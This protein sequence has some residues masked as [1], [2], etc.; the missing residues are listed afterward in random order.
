MKVELKPLDQQVIVITG[1]DSGI[2]LATAREAARRGAAVVLNSRNAQALAQI[3]EELGTAGARVAWHAGDVADPMAMQG[4][5]QVAMDAFGRIDTWVNNAGVTIYGEIEHTPLEDVRR[6]FDTNYFGVV[7]GSLAALPHLR[8]RGGA[9]IN[10]GSVLSGVAIPLQGHYAASKHAVKGFT[11]SLRLELEHRLVPIAVTLIRPAA[12]DTPYT[13]HAHSHMADAD[14]NVPPPVYAPGVVARA[15]LDCAVRPQREVLVGGAAKQMQMLRN[16]PGTL[17]DRY[18][19]TAVWDQQR[20]PL[21]T[22]RRNDALYTPSVSGR[23]RGD[24]DG[25]VMRT[26]AYTHTA[27]HPLQSLLTVGLIGA[28]AYLLSRSGLVGRMDQEVRARFMGGDADGEADSTMARADRDMRHVLRHLEELGPRPIETLTPA[29]ARMQPTPAD[30]VKAML[31]KHGKTPA[32]LPVAAVVDRTIPGP[33]GEIPIRVY[34]PH[35]TGPFPVIVYTHGGGWVIATNDTYDSSAR[36]LCDAVNAVVVSVEYRK[37]PEHRFP[38]AH[39]DALAAYHWVLQNAAELGGD[40]DR[41]AVAGESAGGNLAVSIALLARDNGLP[42]PAHVLAVYP[43]ADGH[44]DSPSYVENADTRPLNRPMMQWFFSHYLRT[45]ADA[46]NPLISLVRA[47]L[48]GLPPTTIITAEI[49][50]LR[51][52][53]ERLAAALRA[54]GVEVDYHTHDGVTHEFFGMAMVVSDAA[55]ALKQAAAGLKRGL[56]ERS[57]AG[58]R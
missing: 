29:E 46:D 53:G 45:P 11:D 27:Q 6:L 50:P 3:G 38:A 33:G 21:G 15:I 39:Q 20:A 37:A 57:M 44:T 42:L 18:A 54:A 2:G 48:H 9:L 49:D 12:I 26:S 19:E 41:V 40:P 16:A 28:G 4:L 31:R 22:K 7:N 5:A 1:A 36:A 13:E 55:K 51:S 58:V 34:A 56:A 8:V 14:P 43:I 24:Y 30:A 47:D 25:H 10:V 35:G 23:E 52:D 17:Y 32:P